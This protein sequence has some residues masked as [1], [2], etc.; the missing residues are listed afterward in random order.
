[1]TIIFDEVNESKVAR[2]KVQGC[3]KVILVRGDPAAGGAFNLRLETMSQ[4]DPRFRRVEVANIP[5][6][7]DFCLENFPCLACGMDLIFTLDIT[8]TQPSPNVF[9]QILNETCVPEK[10]TVPPCGCC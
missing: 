5:G 8:A 2:Y 1:M 10:C 4:C 9:V 7:Q 3:E 6:S